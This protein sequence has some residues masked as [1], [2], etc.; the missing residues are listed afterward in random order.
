M[1]EAELCLGLTLL[2]YLI[3]SL[4]TA[5]FSLCY[6]LEVACCCSS[7]R[8]LKSL[9]ACTQKCV[10]ISFYAEEKV[11]PLIDFPVSHNPLGQS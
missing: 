9:P 1:A 5:V 4:P 7:L 6:L 2:N 8:C 3:T 11:E 10:I